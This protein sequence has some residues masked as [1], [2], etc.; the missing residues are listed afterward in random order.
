[1]LHHELA[2]QPLVRPRLGVAQANAL[3]AGGPGSK[4]Q[5]RVRWQPSSDTG[6]TRAALAQDAAG[7]LAEQHR[8]VVAE[9]ALAIG[10]F[11]ER[12]A[13]AERGQDSPG[14]GDRRV[15]SSVAARD[16][17]AIEGVSRDIEELGVGIVLREAEN[18]LGERRRGGKPGEIEAD[19]RPRPGKIER[20]Q[21][22]E[23]PAL[24]DLE[25]R[26]PLNE[27]I[28]RGAKPLR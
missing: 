8:L 11:L 14:A 13:E 28:Q 24:F 2:K 18:Q 3:A 26:G 20:H 17:H 21:G 6:A 15:T 4:R 1:M 19:R 9:R 27:Q 10:A 12:R 16:R 7:R 23:I 25:L 22:V 5:S